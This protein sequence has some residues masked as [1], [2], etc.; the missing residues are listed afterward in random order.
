[1]TEFLMVGSLCLTVFLPLYL[2]NQYMT[3]KM[4][5]V[6]VAILISLILLGEFTACLELLI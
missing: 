6:S 2:I 4:D 3:D 5:V 1:M